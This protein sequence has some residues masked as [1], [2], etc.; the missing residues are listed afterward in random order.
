[1]VANVWLVCFHRRLRRR[2]MD[3]DFFDRWG[4]WPT[5]DQAGPRS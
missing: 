5:P 3:Q 4:Q 2:R 1:V